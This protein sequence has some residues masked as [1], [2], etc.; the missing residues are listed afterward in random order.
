MKQ[1]LL[2]NRGP[3]SG[4]CDFRD[5]SRERLRRAF[6]RANQL[7]RTAQYKTHILP[8]MQSIFWDSSFRKPSAMMASAYTRSTFCLIDGWRLTHGKVGLPDVI[9]GRNYTQILWWY[10]PTSV[11]RFLPTPRGSKRE[12][13][14]QSNIS[15]PLWPLILKI[16]RIH[17][18]G[19]FTHDSV[20]SPYVT[21]HSFTKV[22]QSVSQ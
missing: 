1:R 9:E 16:T 22:S 10:C 7:R 3:G 12:W 11:S 13:G 14:D 8:V 18:K 2:R 21:I 5:L 4:R 6:T 15:Q 19:T 17:S 20:M